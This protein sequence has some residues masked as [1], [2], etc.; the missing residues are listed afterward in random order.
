MKPVL[1]EPA[2]VLHRR[3][4]RETS[5][6]IELFTPQHGRVS[7]VAKGARQQRS[8]R[9][10]LLQAFVPST[11]SWV[12]KGELMTITAV[13]P[14]GVCV[15]LHGEN[16]YAGLYLNELLVYLLQ[17]WDP[18]PGLFNMYEKT[19]AALQGKTLN[20]KV[21]RSF[22][23]YLIEELGYGFLPKAETILQNTF[24][25]DR[26]YQYVYEQG[27]IETSA[28]D[29]KS[30]INIFSG[31]SLLAFAREDWHD[32]ESLQD[33]K[34]LIRLVLL[35]LLGNKTLNSRQLFVR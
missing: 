19:L 30:K 5:F 6:L 20:Q 16:L 25:P 32:D 21:L 15:Q 18:H 13:E 11:V 35:P 7:A 1:L 27:L 9:H 3:P 10:G 24:S 8:T 14:N 33:A 17:K 22:E 31:K 29:D 2:Y 26:F 4:F 12:G 23:K 28:S 34:R